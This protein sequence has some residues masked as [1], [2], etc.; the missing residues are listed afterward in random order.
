MIRLRSVTRLL[1]S[2]SV[3]ISRRAPGSGLSPSRAHTR[4]RHTADRTRVTRLSA[5]LSGAARRSFS[6]S[7]SGRVDLVF[8]LTQKPAW[9]A[10]VSPPGLGSLAVSRP[11]RGQYQGDTLYTR[12]GRPGAPAERDAP[13]GRPAEIP[14]S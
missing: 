7:N 8:Q 10:I 1:I 2:F 5:R 14:L 9:L 3:C 11:C 6:L 4:H 12:A 13:A